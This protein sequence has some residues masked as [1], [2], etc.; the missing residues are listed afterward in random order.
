MQGDLKKI[1]LTTSILSLSA[2]GGAGLEGPIFSI[3]PSLDSPGYD[4]LAV[5]KTQS[6]K[7]SSVV[8]EYVDHPVYNDESLYPLHT[9]RDIDDQVASSEANPSH[10]DSA[11]NA[12]MHYDASDG[13]FNLSVSQGNVDFYHNFLESERDTNITDRM[14]YDSILGDML[15]KLDLSQPGS[16]SWGHAALNYMSYG[17]WSARAYPSIVSGWERISYGGV[18]FGNETHGS[19][20]P[21]SGSAS[22]SGGTVGQY[23][24][25]YLGKVLDQTRF[26]IALAN[27]AAAGNPAPLATSIRL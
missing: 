3:D 13:S 16:S 15:Y 12:T 23:D 4:Q 26:N 22:Y 6:F 19:D 9:Y 2:C 27:A 14:H 1:L 11:G 17:M 18:A 10:V 8:L 20:M 24:T 21:T 5:D 7:A 25:H